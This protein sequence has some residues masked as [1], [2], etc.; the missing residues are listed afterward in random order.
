MKNKRFKKYAIKYLLEFIVIV[1]GI[2]VSFWVNQVAVEKNENKERVKILTQLKTEIKDIK[3]YTNDRMKYW[4]DD[5][6]LYAM[7]LSSEFETNAIKKITSS[8]SRIEYNLIYYR[9]FQPPMNRYVSI[10]NTGSFKFIKSER[11]KEGLTR[12][13]TINYSNINTS[14]QY[15]KLLKEHLIEIITK[16]IKEEFPIAKKVFIEAESAE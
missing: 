6:D 3:K 4:Q 9:D 5:I 11:I 12:L 16:N 15:E 7:F 13:H 1:L 10:I 8:K 14:V 2:S